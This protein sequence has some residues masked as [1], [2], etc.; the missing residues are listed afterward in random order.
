MSSKSRP[1]SAASPARPPAAPGSS[2]LP[3]SSRRLKGLERQ[4]KAFA[5]E[6]TEVLNGT[7]TDGIRLNVYMDERGRAVVG[8]RISQRNPL[9]TPIPLTTSRA[10]AK[11]HLSVLHTLDLDESGKDLITS[12]STYTL[13]G[14]EA[15]ASIF[16]YDYVREPPNEY[17]EAH[18][19]LHGASDA[20]QNLLSVGNRDADKPADFHLPVGGR[21]YR[22]CLEDIIEFCVLERLVKPRDGWQAAV[23]RGR[24]RYYE[25]QLQAAVRRDPEHAAATLRE[26]GWRVEE[27]Q[28]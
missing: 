25:L 14:A 11:L 4:A 6:L 10:P 8:Y 5:G 15:G 12:R 2:S 13:E 18:L 9:G 17:P 22:P 28:E 24:S 26:K 1:V 7:V 3:L 21:R 20:L 19:H 27:P 23:E 16:T